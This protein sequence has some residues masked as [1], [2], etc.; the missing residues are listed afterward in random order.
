MTILQTLLVFV[1]GPALIYLVMAVSVYT[2]GRARRHQA[3]KV[4]QE[5]Q[6]APQWWAGDQP[7]AV[8]GAGGAAAVSGT[9]RGGARG[10]W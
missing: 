9:T 5:W 3:Y 6:Y 1:G 10:T 7:V 8:P 2:T 4:G